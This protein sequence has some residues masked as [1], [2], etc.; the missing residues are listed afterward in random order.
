MG[1]ELKEEIIYIAG[2]G[3]S[4]STLLDIILSNA[5]N[6]FTLGEISNVFNEKEN[7]T[8]NFYATILKNTLLNLSYSD[9]QIKKIRHA[10]QYFYLYNE[11]YPALWKTFLNKINSNQEIKYFIDSSKTTWQTLFRPLNLKKSGFEV[12]IIFLKASYSKVWKS[13]LKGSNKSLQ[14]STLPRQKNILFAVKSLI[15]KF[16]I[17]SL[18]SCV[19]SKKNVVKINYD[20]LIN[21]PHETIKRIELKLDIEL[22][23]LNQKIN[24]NKYL[25][26][27]GY[28]GNRLR[29]ENTYI[30]INKSQ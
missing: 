23:E 12:K 14:K 22:E 4:G 9:S 10:D 16:L 29:K 15:S 24:Q 6:S 28:L 20:D 11:K 25:V 21:K 2:Y 3:R 7:I 13:T 5:K 26:K 17:D 1:K 27:G 19:Y 8:D 18:T 30:S